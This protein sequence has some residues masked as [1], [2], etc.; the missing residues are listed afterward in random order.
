MPPGLLSHVLEKM[1]IEINQ[2][3]M[4]LQGKQSE[5]IK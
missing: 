2:F 4:F 1:F 3:K 5:K